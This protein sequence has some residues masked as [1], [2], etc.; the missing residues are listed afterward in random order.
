VLASISANM[1][2]RDG[3]RFYFVRALVWEGLLSFP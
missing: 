3:K 1:Y 2:R